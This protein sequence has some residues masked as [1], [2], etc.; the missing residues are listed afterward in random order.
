[1]GNCLLLLGRAY[2]VTTVLLTRVSDSPYLATEST[3]PRLD[4]HS[5]SNKTSVGDKELD[6]VEA[7]PYSWKVKLPSL[8][9]RP[10]QSENYFL[11]YLGELAS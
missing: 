5:L 7:H 1:V 2:R 8:V 3:Q 4:R 6:S 11:A 9:Q 10:R